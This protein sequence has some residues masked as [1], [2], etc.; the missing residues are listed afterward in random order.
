VGGFLFRNTATGNRIA[1]KGMM[2]YNAMHEFLTEQN[3]HFSIFYTK[4]DKPVKKAFA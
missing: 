1:T 2:D 4:A 3:L